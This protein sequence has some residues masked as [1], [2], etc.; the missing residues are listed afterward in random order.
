MK[1][2]LS[3]LIVLLS[4]TA[5]SAS[6]ISLETPQ[7]LFTLSGKAYTEED[8]ME[9]ILSLDYGQLIIQKAEDIVIKEIMDS[10]DYD[11]Q[12]EF[13][14]QYS[15][16]ESYAKNMNMD[17]SQLVAAYGLKDVDAFKAQIERS[18]VMDLYT[19]E[20][21]EE[22]LEA[23]IK[24][25]ELFAID[26]Y[27]IEDKETAEQMVRY[28]Q[29]D[30]EMDA[31]ESEFDL[32]S[33]QEAIYHSQLKDMPEELKMKMETLHKEKAFFEE[34]NEG[35]YAVY[36]YSKTPSKDTAKKVILDDTDFAQKMMIDLVKSKNL[37]I[38]HPVLKKNMKQDFA[39]YIK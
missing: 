9:E 33:P 10:K 14:E 25:Y 18:I 24:K 21:L 19:E 27:Q 37:K 3:I 29:S 7:E 20:K 15:Q 35:V 28:I 4:L 34:V 36:V 12:E 17:M 5:C 6:S 38:Y 39:E 16:F 31:F 8:L 11:I 1:K 13:N 23:Q 32:D 30:Y 22:D 2:I 26:L